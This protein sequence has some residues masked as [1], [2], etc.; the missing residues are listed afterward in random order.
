MVENACPVRIAYG[1]KLGLENLHCVLGILDGRCRLH[2]ADDAAHF[3][4]AINLSKVFTFV[5][6][7]GLGSGNAADVVAHVLIAHV[8][9]VFALADDAAAGT[10]DTADVRYGAD[11]FASGDGLQGN[12]GELNLVFL[13]LVVLTPERLLQLRTTPR[14]FPRRRRPGGRR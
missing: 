7:P 13:G 12:V 6:I 4:A 5:E 2:L 9:T 11:G 10:G 3:L 14:Y 8:A 1:A